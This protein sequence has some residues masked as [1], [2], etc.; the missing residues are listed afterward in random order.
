MNLKNKREPYLSSVKR[1]KDYSIHH[2]TILRLFLSIVLVAPALS[3]QAQTDR[4]QVVKGV[5]HILDIYPNFPETQT[6]F[7]AQIDWLASNRG[8]AD[9]KAYLKPEYGLSLNYGI[10]DN[11]AILGR[12]IGLQGNFQTYH[13]INEK[14]EW[15]IGFAFGGAYFTESY[16]YL[17]N[18]EN[19][20][21]GSNLSFL[22]TGNMGLR[23][24]VSNNLDAVINAKFHHTSNAH[25]VL[26]NVGMNMLLLEAGISYTLRD[27]P[28]KKDSIEVAPT[29]PAKRF[30]SYARIFYG[31]NELGETTRPT[32]GPRYFKTGVAGGVNY[33]WKPG[34]TVSAELVGYYDDANFTYLLLEEESDADATRLNASVLM[35][36]VGHE[37]AF[38]RF[39]FVT[40]LGINLFNPGRQEITNAL[41]NPSLTDQLSNRIPGRFCLHYYPL[42]RTKGRVT[43]MLNIGV[44]THMGGADFLETGIT[45]L[46][47]KIH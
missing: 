9:E 26:P 8:Y 39:G 24:A 36:L 34:H 25:L 16:D 32:N 3:S 46:F 6:S 42:G 41:Q 47:G 7:T 43:P 13:A 38:A 22:A 4:I 29:L 45:L 18:P 2:F 40:Q 33:F 27:M 44:K 12:F 37:F 19:V 17:N 30:R 28:T 35:L 1:T 31:V 10:L 23:H 11:D 20:M 14:T 5:G 21:T 15:T